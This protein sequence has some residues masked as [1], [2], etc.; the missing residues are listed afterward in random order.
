MTDPLLMTVAMK[1]TLLINTGKK[2]KRQS[3]LKIIQGFELHN[4]Y[5]D[6]NGSPKD[7]AYFDNKAK[8]VI[9]FEAFFYFR[10]LPAHLLIVR[11]KIHRLHLFS[12]RN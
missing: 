4:Q 8:A 1:Y 5:F 3:R 12:R 10:N 6:G 9:V 7:I 11:R 2:V